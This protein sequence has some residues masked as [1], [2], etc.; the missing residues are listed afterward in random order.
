MGV[1]L[2]G[3]STHTVKRIGELDYADYKRRDI[4]QTKAP[5]VFTPNWDYMVSKMVDV[6]KS[7]GANGLLNIKI[8]STGQG[9]TA[10][11]FAVKIE[12]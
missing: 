12:E 1:N 5:S 2:I 10:S 3:I 11:G 9:Y 6:A 4:S 7:A 8:Q